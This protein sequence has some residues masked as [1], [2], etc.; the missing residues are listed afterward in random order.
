MHSSKKIEENPITEEALNKA[1]Q[2]SDLIDDERNFQ[3]VSGRKWV[4]TDHFS[5]GGWLMIDKESGDIYGTLG[6]LKVNLNDKVG[7]IFKLSTHDIMQRVSPFLLKPL[8][9]Q[10]Y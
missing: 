4:R 10:Y 1:E 9:L 2:M 5:G 3:V 7:N 8:N 6:H